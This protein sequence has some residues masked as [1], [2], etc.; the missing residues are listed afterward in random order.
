MEAARR[1]DPADIE[2]LE[3]DGH[4]GIPVL[5][6]PLGSQGYVKAYM[7]GKAEERYK[8]SGHGAEDAVAMAMSED[9]VAMARNGLRLPTRLKGDG[10]RRMATARY[11]AFIGCMNDIHQRFL[12]RNSDTNMPPLP[13][14]TR[15]SCPYVAE[16]ASTQLL[17]PNAS[18]CHFGDA[19]ARVMQR[20]AEATSGSQLELTTFLD[21][22]NN[23]RILP[24]WNT[25][26]DNE[27]KDMFP[28][29]KLS[30]PA[31]NVV[32]GSYD[33]RSVKATVLE[34]KT[35]RCGVKYT[36]SPPGQK[37]TLRDIVNMLECTGM[38][39]GTLGEV[40]KRVR[41]NVRGV[42]CLAADGVP[43]HSGALEL[44]N[45]DDRPDRRRPDGGAGGDRY[46]YR[47]L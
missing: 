12:A 40:C 7:R 29:A 6:V 17:L 27:L 32:T 33:P 43:S 2:G 34:F 15:I 24:F 11:A 28:D 1:E 5:N 30:L 35:M 39:F 13:I 19:D 21:Q 46:P 25:A 10:I 45:G 42:A 8:M 36:A 37:G 3:P 38:V 20:E 44:T 22:A 41:R 9:A 18:D 14:L 16:V 23:S 4:R 47:Y 26:P 31:L